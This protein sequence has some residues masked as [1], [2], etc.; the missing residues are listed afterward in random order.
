MPA[1]LASIVKLIVMLSMLLLWSGSTVFAGFSPY[2]SYSKRTQTSQDFI[3]LIKS[4]S[5][6]EQECSRGVSQSLRL[7]GVE[8]TICLPFQ[9]DSTVIASENDWVQ[10][11]GWAKY[12]QNQEFTIYAI[13]YGIH[14]ASD[15]LPLASPGIAGK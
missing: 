10:S 9:P 1:R 13:P 11:A 15:K 12:D 14:P 6:F 8:L 5:T 2:E 3:A 7:D 4:T